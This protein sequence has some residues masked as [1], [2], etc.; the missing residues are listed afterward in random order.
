[1]S[2]Q[3][4]TRGNGQ[5][6]VTPPATAQTYAAAMREAQEVRAAMQAAHDFPRVQSEAIARILAACKRRGL[7]EQALYAY[8]RG[9]TTVTGPSI[10][11]AEAIAQNW[12]NMAFG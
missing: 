1:M 5:W 8:P 4:E 9:N 3:L 7:A 12:G 2:T 11:L 10:R 6:P